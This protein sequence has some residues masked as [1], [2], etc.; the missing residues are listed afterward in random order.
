MREI[1][2]RAFKNGSWWYSDDEAYNLKEYDGVLYLCEDVKFYIN[3]EE[4]EL[5]IIGVAY[6]YTGLK[7]KN[8][9]EIYEGDLLK[10][11]M[12]WGYGLAEIIIKVYFENGSFRAKALNS[13]E[14]T[15][16]LELPYLEVIGN[17][18]EDS[19]LLDNN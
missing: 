14:D 1:K 12:D 19:H 6:Q 8:G 15:L 5:E 7:D 2:F 10:I 4:Y 9:V 16:L 18:Y 11:E 13:H 3:T 17:I